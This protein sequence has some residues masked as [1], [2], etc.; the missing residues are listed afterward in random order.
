MTLDISIPEGRT[1]CLQAASN[2]SAPS[3]L[4]NGRV[5]GESSGLAATP[6]LQRSLPLKMLTD[7]SAA[8]GETGVSPFHTLSVFL[9]N[10]SGS[11]LTLV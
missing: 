1:I 3:A 7:N 5:P 4:S 6:G 9:A 8:F 10:T 2:S 11:R